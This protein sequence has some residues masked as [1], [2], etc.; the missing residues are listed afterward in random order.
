[1]CRQEA[2]LADY[3]PRFSTREWWRIRFAYYRS[4]LW[5]N[6][7]GVTD[8]ATA[9]VNCSGCVCC[10]QEGYVALCSAS[11]ECIAKSSFTGVCLMYYNTHTHTRLTALYPGL[12]GW[13]GTR[14][15]KPIR[16]L[17]K[18]ETVSGGGISWTICMSASRSRQITMPAPH[19]SF[20]LQAGCPSCHPTNSVKALKA[21]LMYYNNNNNKCICMAP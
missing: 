16:I 12:P 4:M 20:F 9:V 17:L 8:A 14:K 13:A 5:S 10:W 15:V 3:I 11:K 7:V 2:E 19:C 21:S 18:Q 6:F 1:M